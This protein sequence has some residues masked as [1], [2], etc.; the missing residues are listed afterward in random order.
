M[1]CSELNTADI[2]DITIAAQP[3]LNSLLIDDVLD[4]SYVC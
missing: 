1:P 3:L 2:I 4:N